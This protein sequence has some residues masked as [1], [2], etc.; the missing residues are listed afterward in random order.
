MFFSHRVAFFVFCS[1]PCRILVDR[2]GRAVDWGRQVS[3]MLSKP[4]NTKI[5]SYSDLIRT[6]VW[7]CFSVIM[8]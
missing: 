6:T 4:L 5:P 7:S 3:Q 2:L 1:F 8:H